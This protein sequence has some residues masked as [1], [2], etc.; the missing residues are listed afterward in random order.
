MSDYWFVLRTNPQCERKAAGEL[1]RRGI[2]VYIPKQAREVRNRRCGQVTVKTRP[3]LVGY[4][5]I[6]FTGPQDWFHVRQCQGVKGVLYLD[7]EPGRIPAAA[8]AEFMRRQRRREFGR[9]D[10]ESDEKRMRRLQTM[11]A[12]GRRVR[13]ADGPFSSFLATIEQIKK[14]GSIKALVEIFGRPAVVT[15]ED[16]DRCLTSQSA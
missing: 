11:F 16:P 4:V 8:V 7:G 5:F 15:F 2:R 10:A 13:V 9:P 1:R 12:P 14:D 6:R 3:L